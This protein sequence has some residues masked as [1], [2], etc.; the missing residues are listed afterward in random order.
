MRY[1]IEFFY[2]GANFF[3]YQIQPNKITV[4]EEL[5]VLFLPFV[6]IKT[7]GAGRTDTGVH[8]KNVCSFDTEQVI[9]QNSVKR[10]NAFFLLRIF[11]LKVFFPKEKFTRKTSATLQNL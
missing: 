3:G 10:L 11:Q 4:Q 7:T 1:F 5:K 6:E 9:N 8:A 2:N